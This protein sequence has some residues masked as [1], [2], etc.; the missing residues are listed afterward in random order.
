MINTVLFDLDGTLM[1]TERLYL[2]SN[3]QAA[4]E[5]GFDTPQRDF[6]ALVGLGGADLENWLAE[7]YGQAA[8]QPF[9]ERS[10]ALVS[11][12]LQSG[13][14][15]EMP[16]ATALLES[17][18][19]EDYGVGIVTSAPGEHLVDAIDSMGWHD[20]VTWRISLDHG[21]AKPA[22]DLYLAGLKAADKKPAEVLAVEDTPLGVA[23]ARA[24]GLKTLQIADLAPLSE[25]ATAT[26]DKLADIMVWLH[27]NA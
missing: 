9:I 10:E 23:A 26:V 15:R 3:Q 7:R 21:A 22:P 1:D 13:Q 5:L 17:L 25:E 11:D 18:K 12:W 4:A 20:L 6:Y 2:K 14:G 19:D 27:R 24:A 16:G 8:V